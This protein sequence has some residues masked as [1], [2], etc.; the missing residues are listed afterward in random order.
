MHE[1]DQLLASSSVT[2]SF[3][4]A[5]RT[6]AGGGERP[7]HIAIR[8]FIPPVKVA[9]LLKHLLAESGTL[10]I[11]RVEL[12][13]RSG[14]SDFEG[15]VHVHTTSGTVAYEFVWDCKWKAEQEG[16]TDYFG[17]PDQARAAREYDWRCF[18]VWRALPS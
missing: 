18:R 7:E 14:C 1:F 8:G 2:D 11:E 9:R 5:V 4:D 16:W 10:P 17:F 15:R 13:G 12:D 3:K 6:V